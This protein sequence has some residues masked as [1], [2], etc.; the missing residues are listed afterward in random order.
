MELEEGWSYLQGGDRTAEAAQRKKK[1]EKQER[2]RIRRQKRK[3]NDFEDKGVKIDLW[4]GGA[5]EAKREMEKRKGKQE[6]NVARKF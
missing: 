5:V 1:K 6:L 4:G 3:G 2:V